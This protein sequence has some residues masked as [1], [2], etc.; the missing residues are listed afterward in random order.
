[1]KL[2]LNDKNTMHTLGI[3]FYPFAKY[4]RI[5]LDEIDLNY[6]VS[7]IKKDKCFSLILSA[8]LAEIENSK[9]SKLERAYVQI[10][11]IV[12]FDKFYNDAHCPKGCKL[13]LFA[14]LG[15]YRKYVQEKFPNLL[16]ERYPYVERWLETVR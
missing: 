4:F 9:L 10:N 7:V 3:P 12:F 13:L 14:L 16:S 11:I 15:L 2:N 5:E 8:Y 1:M 6:I